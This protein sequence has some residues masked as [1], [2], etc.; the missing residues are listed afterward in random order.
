MD[1]QA[2]AKDPPVP[3]S[4]AL[5]LQVH[6]TPAFLYVHPGGSNSGPPVWMASTLLTELPPLA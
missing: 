3:S 2:S 4:L 1:W 5:G 6:P